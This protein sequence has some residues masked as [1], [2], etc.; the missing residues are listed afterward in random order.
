MSADARK[1]KILAHLARTS[2][3]LNI[4]ATPQ[5]MTYTPPAAPV[6]RANSVMEHLARSSANFSPQKMSPE[7]RKQ[8][9]KDHIQ[10]SLGA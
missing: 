2:D 10:R 3:S 8:Q 4:G 6:T 5:K 9:I 1:Q 7:D